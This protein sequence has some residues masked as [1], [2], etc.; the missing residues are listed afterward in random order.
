MKVLSILVALR[1]RGA[2]RFRQRR[3]EKRLST[4]KK[5]LFG[6]LFLYMAGVMLIMFGGVAYG[7]ITQLEP[8]GLSWVALALGGFAAAA[9]CFLF[10]VFSMQSLLFQAKDN[11][12]LLSLPLRPWQIAASRLLSLL[13]LEYAFSLVA[14]GPTVGV[15]AWLMAPGLGFYLRLIPLLLL[16]PLLPLALAAFVGYLFALVTARSRHKSLLVT[17]LSFGAFGV[18]MYFCLNLNKYMAILATQGETLGN[19]FR[20]AL[21]PFYHFALGLENGSIVSLLWVGLWCLLPA[22]LLF[23][24]VSKGFLRVASAGGVK[25]AYKRQP[26]QSSAPWLAVF[27]KEWVRFTSMPLFI[28]NSA[29]GILMMLT[30]VVIMAIKGGDTLGQLLEIPQFSQFL[31]QGLMAMLCFCIS[32]TC[33]TAPC[34]SLE[35]N[36]LWVL[37]S[38]PLATRDIFVGKLALNLVLMLP[39]LVVSVVVLTVSMG[40]SWLDA[41]LLLLLPGCLG[42]F[43]A[44]LGLYAN[45]RF[46]RFDYISDT[47]V[48]KQS[49]SVMVTSLGSMGLVFGLVFLYV[50]WLQRLMPFV[51]FCLLC[52]ALLA[53]A[54]ALLWHK[55]MTDGVKRFEEF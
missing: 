35:G 31:T 10:S 52:S 48:I 9:I 33:T 13:L 47:S 40:L 32:M 15:Y 23:V 55:I 53:A 1:L 26:L 5:V 22:A 54:C 36:K 41:L 42:L 45:L 21:P 3:D 19:V 34:I 49:A 43:V 16:L 51:P 2:F 37:R 18:Y 27:K 30:L 24:L 44:L 20:K 46:P 11:D 8:L 28:F 6:L 4:G 39:A 17:V 14:L 7:L 29:M 50:F 38:S 12:L 25:V